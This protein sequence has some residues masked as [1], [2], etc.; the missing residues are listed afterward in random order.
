MNFPQIV[1]LLA[2][3]V[4]GALGAIRPARRASRVDLIEALH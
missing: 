4:L 1:V 3:I 2:S